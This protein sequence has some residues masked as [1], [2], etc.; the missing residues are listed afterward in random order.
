MVTFNNEV[1]IIGDGLN[2]ESTVIAGDKLYKFDEIY[3]TAQNCAAK[4]L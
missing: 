1:V 3:N 2:P 4:M